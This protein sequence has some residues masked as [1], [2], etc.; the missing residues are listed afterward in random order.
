MR[1]VNIKSVRF[2]AED[3]NELQ[4]RYGNHAPPYMEGITLTLEQGYEC[5]AHLFLEDYEARRLRDLFNT[6]YPVKS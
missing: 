6:L 2:R 5:H 4:V 3:G 1:K